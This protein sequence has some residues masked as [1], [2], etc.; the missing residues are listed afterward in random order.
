M[1]ASALRANKRHRQPPIR[2]GSCLAVPAFDV[3]GA[4]RG[5]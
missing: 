1:A 2:P 3:V 4:Q 5:G